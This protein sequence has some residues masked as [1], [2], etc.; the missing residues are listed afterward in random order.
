MSANMS[1]LQE[2]VKAKGLKD[3]HFV[4]FSVDPDIDTPEVL[5]TYGKAFGADFS[6]WHFLTGF[7]QQEIEDF[8]LESFRSHVKKPRDDDQV[9]H[10]IRFYLV[11]K[12]GEIIAD[13]P[14]NEDVPFKEIM[15][16]IKDATKQ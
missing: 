10:G 2:D 9:M 12:N 7:T 11:N 8:A 5:T 1:Q 16:N 14:G 6:M 4:S 15:K 13:Y 3:V